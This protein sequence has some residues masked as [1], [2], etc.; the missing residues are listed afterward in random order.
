MDQQQLLAR[1]L[2]ALDFDI[3]SGVLEKLLRYVDELEQWNPVYGFVKAKG[4]DLIIK[5]VLDS[6]GPWRILEDLF[7]EMDKQFSDNNKLRIADIGT[8][9]GFPGIPLAIAFP[10]RSFLLIERLE[11]RTRF[12]ENVIYILGLENV[13]IHQN[14]VEDE[15]ENLECAIFIA[16]RPFADKKLFR[17]IWK[18]IKLGGALCA[19]KGRIMHAKLELTGLLDDP[20]LSN[21]AAHA[22]ITPVWVPFLEEE[23]CLVIARKTLNI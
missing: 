12:L 15:D 22:K 18:K 13:E 8:G 14:T 2:A 1:G 23:R 5:H 21:M 19:Y 11:K 4:Q 9:A 10:Q 6:L 20:V 16:L 3:S 17:T 7:S